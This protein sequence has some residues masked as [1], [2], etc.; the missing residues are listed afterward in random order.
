MQLVTGDINAADISMQHSPK[1]RRSVPQNTFC[2]LWEL[3]LQWGDKAVVELQLQ[4]LH[5]HS[6]IALCF[7]IVYKVS[8]CKVVHRALCLLQEASNS[9]ISS[10][11]K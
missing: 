7:P 2:V 9:F 4:Y 1:L 11:Y 6:F 10:V 8:L 3:F 5:A